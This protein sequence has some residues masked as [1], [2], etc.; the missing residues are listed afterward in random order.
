LST[1]YGNNVRSR[2]LDTPET[3]D[4]VDVGVDAAV[5]LEPRAG[6]PKK[7]D[8]EGWYGLM[9]YVRAYRSLR[10]PQTRRPR[11]GLRGSRTKAG[12]LQTARTGDCRGL[13][14]CSLACVRWGRG[15]Q[16]WMTP[17]SNAHPAPHTHRY[18]DRHL[19]Y[20][21][22]HVDHGRAD[23]S[24]VRLGARTITYFKL[25]RVHKGGMGRCKSMTYLVLRFR[26]S[27]PLGAG[28][29]TAKCGPMT[30][31]LS[32]P[33]ASVQLRAMDRRRVT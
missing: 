16:L 3:R 7:Y 17:R 5:V 18:V 12:V 33:T 9:R 22:R 31:V 11:A 26:L 28:T 6:G 24:D 4:A 15:Y 13:A 21:C 27:V 14:A 10:S 29:V 2:L 20:S 19:Q 8:R 25:L 32:S 23:N 1:E 30:W